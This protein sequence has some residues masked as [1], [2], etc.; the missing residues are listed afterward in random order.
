MKVK[1][2]F[3]A[4]TQG[5]VISPTGERERHCTPMSTAAILLAD[6]IPSFIIKSLSPFLPYNTNYR[7]SISC[8]TSIVSFV[9]VALASSRSIVIFG[10]AL[11][12]FAAGLGEPTF[13]AHSTHY[14][15]N[16]ISTWSSGTGGAGVIGALSYSLLREFGLSSRQAL[17][18]MILVPTLEL[19]TFNLLLNKPTIPRYETTD[20]EHR[21]LVSEV[22]DH[23]DHNENPPLT[24][25]ARKF[26]YIPELMIY[27]LPLTMVYF[28]EYFINQGLVRDFM[29]LRQCTS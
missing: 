15:K 10:V 14:N 22:D 27:F 4:F 26:A 12:S 23:V 7:V 6:I 8:A 28:F 29:Q 20:Q 16:V 19:L 25:I 1:I 11:T 24:T 13:L 5:F 2:F 18:L 9:V 17:L 21:G 3:C